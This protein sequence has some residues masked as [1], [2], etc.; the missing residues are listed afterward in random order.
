[1]ECGSILLVGTQAIEVSLDIDYD[2]IFTEPAPLDALIQRFGRVNRKREKGICSAVV[3]SEKNATDKYIYPDQVVDRTL[4]ALK[5]I[6]D[7]NDGLI[8]EGELE[9]LLNYVYPD[10]S[11]KEHQVFQTTFDFLK[12]SLESLIPM[13]HSKRSEEEFYSKF[14]GIKVL[15][16]VFQTEY[17]TLLNEFRFIEAERLKVQIRKGKFAQLVNER[18]DNLQKRSFAWEAGKKVMQVDYWVLHKKYSE[19]IGIDYNAQ[20]EWSFDNH[21]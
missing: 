21:L 3:F 4:D 17:T 16:A 10:W 2:I 6:I 13:L 8:R 15:P 5:R 14:D 19:D 9:S 1:K 20:E 12:A 18:D 11:P 7:Q